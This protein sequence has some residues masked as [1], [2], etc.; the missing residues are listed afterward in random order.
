MLL[1]AAVRRRVVV[2]GLGVVSPIGMTVESFGESL[3]AGRS[4]VGPITIFDPAELPTR[5]AAEVDR[6]P[7][8]CE[9]RDR[10]IDFALEAA[11][12]AAASAPEDHDGAGLSL[13]L[14]LELFSL[15]DLVALERPDFRLPDSLRDRLQL[16]QTPSDL[17]VHLICHRH[18][19]ATPPLTHVSACAAGNDAVG[20][21]FRLVASG[22]RR[23]MLAGGSDSMINPM[24]LAGFGKIQALSTRNDAPEA[25]SRPFDRRR[26]GFVLGEGAAML[27]LEPLEDARARG[28]RVHAEVVGYGNSFDA[29][30]ISRPHPEG[31][32][33]LQAMSRALDEAG[34][35]PEAIGCVSAHGTSTP[36]NDVVETRAVRALLGGATDVPVT[37]P[38]SMF[39]HLI[40]AAGA[41]ESVAAILALEA[42]VVPPTINLTEPDPECD[43]DHVS[44]TARRHE[45]EYVLSNSF[46]FGGQNSSLVLRRCDAAG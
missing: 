43:L 19:L 28:A 24:G 8:E 46:G 31:R 17:C 30:G 7:A 9:F 4:G 12:Q 13:A 25:A 2:T 36:L 27:V 18:G 33:A 44:P 37:A 29:D 26:D 15:E 11:A 23:W 1:E 35:G 21:A 14:G 22:R 39:G 6:P 5:F 41:V 20:T 40:A 42:G 3:F 10:K 34:I 16:L 38:K 45:H 32:G